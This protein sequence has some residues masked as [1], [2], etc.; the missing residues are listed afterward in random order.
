MRRNLDFQP[1][2]LFLRTDAIDRQSF[3]AYGIGPAGWMTGG[4]IGNA[5]PIN[6]IPTLF[7]V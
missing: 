5:M 7:H 3:L 1:A 2:G 6:N 4:K